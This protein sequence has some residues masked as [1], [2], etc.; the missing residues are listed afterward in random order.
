MNHVKSIHHLVEHGD[1]LSDLI[2][3]YGSD[4]T[5]DQMD[6]L[7]MGCGVAGGALRYFAHRGL[8]RFQAEHWSLADWQREIRPFCSSERNMT[9]I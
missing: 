9:F 5:L 3:S 8:K 7:L 1:Q 2:F 4:Q 6:D